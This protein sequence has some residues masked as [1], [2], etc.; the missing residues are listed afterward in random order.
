MNVP[1]PA[2][3][4]PPPVPARRGEALT[5]V[6]GR[7]RE[8]LPAALEILET[9]PSPLPVAIM[10]T[11]CVFSAVAL[12]WSFVGRLDVHAI[13]WGKVE[14]T[15]RE[16]VVQPVEAGKVARFNAQ[17]GVRVR[18][19]ETLVELDPS[20]ARA[21]LMAVV[22]ALAASDAEAARRRVAIE[23]AGRMRLS[24]LEGDMPGAAVAYGAPAIPFS[25]D[26][27]APIQE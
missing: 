24:A 20:E 1:V 18:A 7:D 27:S 17:N 14:A 22:E 23:T 12:A 8:F 25:P 2:S 26:I 5:V 15:G 16:K 13:A 6:G 10:S 11:I 4:Q 21:D 19:G 9:P 3:R